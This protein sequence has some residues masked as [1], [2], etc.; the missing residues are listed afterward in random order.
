[1]ERGFVCLGVIVGFLFGAVFARGDVIT[2]I[3]VEKNGSQ[4]VYDGRLSQEAVALPAGKYTYVRRARGEVVE[5]QFVPR[6]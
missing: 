6:K 3:P 5:E 4:I 1:M 2:T